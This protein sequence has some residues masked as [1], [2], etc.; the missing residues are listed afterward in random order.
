MG[1]VTFWASSPLSATEESIRRETKEE[2]G[3]ETNWD[4][5]KASFPVL[6]DDIQTKEAKGVRKEVLGDFTKNKRDGTEGAAGFFQL[7]GRKNSKDREEKQ[8]KGC[9]TE[10]CVALGFLPRLRNFRAFNRG[11][12]KTKAQKGEGVEP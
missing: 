11:N 5:G 4:Q 7:E 12:P 8:K 3:R 1:E 6:A 2:K 10:T 9:K